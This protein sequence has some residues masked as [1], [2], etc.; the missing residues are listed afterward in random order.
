MR[1]RPAGSAHATRTRN[2]AARR[3]GAGTTT[4][5]KNREFLRKLRRTALGTFGPLPFIRTDQDFAI[6]RAFLTMKFVNRHG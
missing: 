6:L 3:L 5:S 2:S 4:R 1:M